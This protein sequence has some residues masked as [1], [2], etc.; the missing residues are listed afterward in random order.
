[1]ILAAAD[2]TETILIGSVIGIVAS[3]LTRVLLG[4]VSIS[5]SSSVNSSE[6]DQLR[7]LNAKVDLLLEHLNIDATAIDVRKATMAAEEWKQLATDPSQKIA[8]IKAYRDLTGAGLADAKDAV[9]EYIQSL[10]T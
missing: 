2:I 3:I 9:E 1:M 7:Q 6:R 5:A 10:A 8:A 4:G